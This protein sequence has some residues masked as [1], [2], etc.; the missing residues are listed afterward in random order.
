[1][2]SHSSSATPFASDLLTNTDWANPSNNIIGVLFPNFF[3][4]YFGQ[5]FPQGGIS[6]NDI[7]VNFAKL[8]AGYNL[9]VSAAAKAIDKK[10]DIYEVLGAAS[11]QTDYSRTDFFKSH[12]FLSYD[13]A[14][15]LPIASGPHGFISIVDSD[16]YPV[17]ADELQKFFILSLT[18]L[19]PATALSNLNILTL[20]IPSN[21]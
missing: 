1:M 14:K 7:K 6:S 11:E 9:C 18:S 15:S 19:L 8:G 16:L 17:E 13:P 12:F 3:I 10:N 5:D 4:V 21:I 2:P 20:Q